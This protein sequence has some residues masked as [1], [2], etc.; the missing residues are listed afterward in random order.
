MYKKC[1]FLVF[2]FFFTSLCFADNN[3]QS[4]NN[5]NISTSA[6]AQNKKA[7]NGIFNP[8]EFASFQG[9]KGDGWF[10]EHPAYAGDVV[11][12]VIGVVPAAIISEPFRLIFRFSSTG[13]V[14]GEYTLYGTTKTFGCLF[15]GPSFLL[16]G[17]FYDIPIW[18]YSSIF[19]TSSPSKPQPKQEAKTIKPAVTIQR[20]R[21][22]PASTVTQKIEHPVITSISAKPSMLVS[23]T[24]EKSS[25]SE[26]IKKA[27]KKVEQPA[28]VMTKPML[29]SEIPPTSA[30]DNSEVPKSD[31]TSWSTPP[32]LPDWVKQE[33]KK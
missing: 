28:P 14:V 6:I 16:K 24:T 13:D 26:K 5:L 30:P 8:I 18:I 15:G 23:T 4:E 1:S 32:P 33:I 25:R 10:V 22:I 19:G 21:P 27:P 31:K 17:A 20:E 12:Y 9:Y 3:I 29:E 11:G 7:N 2:L